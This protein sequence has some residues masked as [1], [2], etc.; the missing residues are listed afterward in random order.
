ML[1]KVA[2]LG[3]VAGAHAGAVELTT[4]DSFEKLVKN[5]GKSAFIKFQAPW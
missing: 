4:P 2:L 1:A 3:L 5:S